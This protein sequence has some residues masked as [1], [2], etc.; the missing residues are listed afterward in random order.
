MW[1]VVVLGCCGI[2]LYVVEPVFQA[3]RQAILLQDYRESIERAANEASN[4]VLGIRTPTKAPEPGAPVAIIE[5]GALRLRQVVVEGVS[6]ANTQAGPGHVPGTAAPGQPGNSVVLG[7]RGAFGGPFGD[8]DRLQPGDEILVWTTQGQVA[9]TVNSVTERTIR[10]SPQELDVP[11]NAAATGGVTESGH[12]GDTITTDELYGPTEKD[13]LTLV[14]SAEAVPWNATRATVVVAGLEGKPF[15][16]TPQNGRLDSTTGLGGDRSAVP[17]VL[18]STLGL[19]SAG[20]ATVL[21][22]RRASFRS[23]YLLTTPVLV[24]LLIVTVENLVRLLPAWM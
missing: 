21:L 9:Y 17:A 20:V 3:R 16:P 10:P 15:P 6:P 24:V 5:I 7:R 12:S 13:Q 18:L 1:V 4:P 8:L 23:A 2:V 14:T 11:V 22:Y 19:L